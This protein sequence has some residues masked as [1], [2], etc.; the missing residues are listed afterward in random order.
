MRRRSG[1]PEN[2]IPN[3]S[4]ASRSYQLAA[5]QIPVSVS[6]TGK[7]SSTANTRSRTR[8]LCSIESRYE[9][10][11]KRAPFQGLPEGGT[12]GPSEEAIPEVEAAPAPDGTAPDSRSVASRK[13]ESCSLLAGAPSP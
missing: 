5:G 4:K 7:L 6:T 11:A 8:Q 12:V 9:V 10:A 13:P 2:M 3:R 1:W